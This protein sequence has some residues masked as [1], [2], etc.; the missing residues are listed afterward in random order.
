MV[1]IYLII[2][3]FSLVGEPILRHLLRYRAFAVKDHGFMPY[4]LHLQ[5]AWL[6]NKASGTSFI[7]KKRRFLIHYQQS[8]IK[9]LRVI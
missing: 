8:Q 3:V 9:P 2:G 5:Q 6:V 1:N 4:A 7:H